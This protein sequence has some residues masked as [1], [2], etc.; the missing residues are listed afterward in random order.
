[1]L[2]AAQTGQFFQAH[3]LAAVEK[4]GSAASTLNSAVSQELLAFVAAVADQRAW[5]MVV[6]FAMLKCSAVAQFV[7]QLYLATRT[8][9]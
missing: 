2:S 4:L 6:Q 9:Q 8:S 1:V 7:M 3:V 5:T